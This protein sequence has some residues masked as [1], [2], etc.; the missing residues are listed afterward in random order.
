VSAVV[1]RFVLWQFG[2]ESPEKVGGTACVA[3]FERNFC[4]QNFAKKEVISD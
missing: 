1:C 4:F 2:L 3:D